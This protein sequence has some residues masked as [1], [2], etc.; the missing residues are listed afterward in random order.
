MMRLRYEV[1]TFALD[2]PPA[3]R[4]LALLRRVV[5]DAAGVSV[6]REAVRLPEA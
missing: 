5:L 4:R 6:G 2:F 1:A 3:T